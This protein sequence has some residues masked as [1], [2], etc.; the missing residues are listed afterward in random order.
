VAP[1]RPR[2]GGSAL[3]AGRRCRLSVRLAPVYP[4]ISP[5]GGCQTPPRG[6]AR[7][8]VLDPAGQVVVRVHCAAYTGVGYAE[9]SAFFTIAGTF[10]PFPPETLKALYPTHTAY[11]E[12]VTASAND[13]VAKR[14]LLP[15]D[16]DAYIEAA[17][18]SEIGQ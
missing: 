15:E 11:T 6:A 2:E 7:N 8:A 10:K 17:K 1:R 14:Y 9:D 3:L 18:R 12:A 4:R 16:G 5:R 13:L